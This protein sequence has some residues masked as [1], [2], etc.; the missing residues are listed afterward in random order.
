MEGNKEIYDE[1]KE[2][3]E[4]KSPLDVNYRMGGT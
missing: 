4:N 3:K 2:K 1:S